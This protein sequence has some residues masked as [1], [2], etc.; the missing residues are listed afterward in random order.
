MR[1]RHRQI[2]QLR[3]L[4]QRM[5]G[6]ALTI[7]GKGNGDCRENKLLIPEVDSII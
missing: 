1:D 7:K 2:N 6:R 3:P 5:R 4:K